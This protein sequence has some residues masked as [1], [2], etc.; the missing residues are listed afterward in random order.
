MRA[1]FIYIYVC[2]VLS[3][4]ICTSS[5]FVNRACIEC[6]SKNKFEK[7]NTESKKKEREVLNNFGIKTA[8]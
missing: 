2:M 7:K 1:L 4:R 5:T 8:K 3:N 6:N